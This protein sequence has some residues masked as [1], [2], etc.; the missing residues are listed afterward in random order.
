MIEA[1]SAIKT[2]CFVALNMIILIVHNINYGPNVFDSLFLKD[3][4]Y[5]PSGFVKTNLI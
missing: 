5:G 1:Q 2:L 3:L 4:A